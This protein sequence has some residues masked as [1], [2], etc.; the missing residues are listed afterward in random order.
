MTRIT[1]L[2]A[3]LTLLSACAGTTVTRTQPLSESAD[4][5]YENVLVI[6]LFKSFEARRILEKAIVSELESR[7][8]QAVASTSRMN[9][10]TPVNRATF[11]N[12]VKALDSDAVLV[13]QLVDAQAQA[14]MK[15][16]NPERTRIFRS[17]VY[18][19]VWTTELTEYVEPQALV[20]DNEVV[21][22]A[23]IFSV[24]DREPVW[25]VETRTKFEQDFTERGRNYGL[26]ADEAK[27]I[28]SYMTKDG[29]LNP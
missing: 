9:T 12:M 4:A 23:E 27:K 17:T 28:V 20:L 14:K 11:E 21:L 2:F 29:L 3:V 7:G 6:S 16:M 13:T 26:I 22:S 18:Y 24:K 15:D 10:R 1:T 19:N 8:V 5:P 25:A